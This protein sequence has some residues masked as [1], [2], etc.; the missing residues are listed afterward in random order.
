MIKNKKNKKEKVVILV[1]Y[2]FP[3]IGSGIGNI[4]IKQAEGLAKMGHEVSL[5][6]SNIPKGRSEFTLKDVK[7]YKM[8]STDILEKIKIPIPLFFLNKKVRKVI[9]SADVLHIHGMIYPTSLNMAFLSLIYKKPL[10]LT[11]HV[12]PVN[13]PKKIFVWA[14]NLVYKTSGKFISKVSNKIIYYNHSVKDWLLDNK[15]PNDKLNFLPNG[16]DLELF[17]K[18]N[19]SEKIELRKKY[20]LDNNKK[21]VL[22]VGRFVP[23]KG[24]W[25]VFD[26]RS[27]DYLTIFVGGGEVP[28]QISQSKDCKVFPPLPQEKLVEL[29]QLSDLF[30]L[31]S[32]NEGFPLAIQEAM[33]C[34]LPIITSKHPGYE[35]HITK[36][37]VLTINP[38]K[39]NVK[40][41]IEQ[42]I[43]NEDNLKE[44]S[45]NA[46][47]KALKDFSWE[48]NCKKLMNI[49]R[50]I[51]K[52]KYYL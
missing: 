10:F 14:Q 22:F 52:W 50:G 30:V 19:Q 48:L 8:N 20:E 49:Y 23:K 35:K 24:F 25:K 26:A 39:E 27:K 40:N 37:E 6:S 11:Q 38:T 36:E 29:Y 9:K 17:K 41:S 16:V 42:L 44:M 4:A 43:F 7:H 33:C 5:I 1:T 18:V 34:G 45:D 31:P 2:T 13:Y 3:Y 21:I 15:I 28:E 47:K 32:E 51:T 46:Y 12:G